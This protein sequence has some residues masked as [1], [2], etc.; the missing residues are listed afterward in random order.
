MSEATPLAIIAQG[1]DHR[2]LHAMI[3]LV[4]TAAAAK[5]QSH[6][7]LTF[8]ALHSVLSDDWEALPSG[9][10]TAYGDIYD[11]AREEDRVT[12]LEALLERARAS[13]Y[14]KLYGC[15]ASIAL[16]RGYTEAQLEQ[17]DGIVGHS[18]FLKWALPWQL[19]FIS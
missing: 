16:R 7:F 6:V 4:A 14:V 8:E 11:R 3:S 15:S 5:R 2:H 13:G 19:V 12:D 17:L 1:G 10:A 9:Y 18:T